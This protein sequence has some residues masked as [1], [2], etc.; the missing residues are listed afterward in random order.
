MLEVE[1]DRS[2]LRTCTPM[3]AW[4]VMGT[5][6]R[7]YILDPARRHVD[8]QAFDDVVEEDGLRWISADASF[9]LAVEALVSLSFEL[10]TD[11]VLMG[12]QS[13]V[14]SFLYR[15]ARQGALIRDLVYGCFKDERSWERIAGEPQAWEADVFFDRAALACEIERLAPDQLDAERAELAR[16]L[17]GYRER[18]LRSLGSLEAREIARR[19]ASF[20][21]LP[22]WDVKEDHTSL[23]YEL[24]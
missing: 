12:F 11:V 16:R 4:R 5:L 19:V 18:D 21:G 15:H 17:A 9:E 3:L 8:S 6:I 14:D 7:L 24:P 1:N 10:D 20:L 23:W 2:S 22:G 13:S